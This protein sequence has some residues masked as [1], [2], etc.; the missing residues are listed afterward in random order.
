MTQVIIAMSLAK[1]GLGMGTGM[2]SLLRKKQQCHSCP[3]AIDMYAVAINMGE[4]V[5]ATYHENWHDRSGFSFPCL[6]FAVCE[7]AACDK[8]PVPIDGPHDVLVVAWRC[9]L[10]LSALE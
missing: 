2:I 7:Y 6:I 4:E 3:C 1:D 9:A 5:C 10:H 8:I